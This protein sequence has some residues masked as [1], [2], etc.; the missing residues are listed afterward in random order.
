MSDESL[1]VQQVET[2]E[3]VE[4]QQVVESKPVSWIDSLSDELKGNATLSKFKDVESLAKSYVNAQKLIGSSVKVPGEGATEQELAEFYGKLGRPESVDKYNLP[5]LTTGETFED[6]KDSLERMH[7]ANL[8]D[9]QVKEIL[10]IHN[11]RHSKMLEAIQEK[12]K[13]DEES[14]KKLW[15][16]DYDKN[17]SLAKNTAKELVDKFGDSAKELLA[18]PLANNPLLLSMLAELGKNSAEGNSK[19]IS[20]NGSGQVDSEESI[21]AQINEI[22]KSQD[23]LNPA[24]RGYKEAG[25]KLKTLYGKLI[26]IKK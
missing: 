7:K 6:L 1:E 19:I 5:E 14:V 17:I 16:N 23:F 11:D 20:V 8:T 12:A 2:V 3:A 13:A 22:R 10:A 21:K 25:E 15:G 26:S 4:P 24:S 9:A 18:S